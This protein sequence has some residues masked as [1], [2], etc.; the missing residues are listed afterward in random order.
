MTYTPDYQAFY[1]CQQALIHHLGQAGF[2]STLRTIEGYA[3]HLHQTQ[4]SKLRTSLDAV[5]IMYTGGNPAAQ[6]PRHQFDLFILTKSITIN[7]KTNRNNNLELAGTLAAYLRE[8]FR[9]GPAVGKK[10]YEILREDVAAVPERMAVDPSFCLT[11]LRVPIV[12]HNP[13]I[14]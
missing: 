11:T 6:K 14:Q 1:A 13:P 12:D 3:G 10:V 9:F 8:S 7:R 5:L 2:A 4:I